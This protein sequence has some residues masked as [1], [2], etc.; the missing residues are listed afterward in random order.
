MWC[1]QMIDE[2]YRKRMYDVLDLYSRRE[3]QLHVIAMD[4]KPKEIHAEK[5]NN[6]HETW[7]SQ[8]GRL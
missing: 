5:R 8:E 4:E 2:E 6:T 3:R 1:I 7:P